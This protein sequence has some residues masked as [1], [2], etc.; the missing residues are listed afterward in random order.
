MNGINF[1]LSA[2][3]IMSPSK[4]LCSLLLNSIRTVQSTV[5]LLHKVVLR[6]KNTAACNTRHSFA[7]SDV[8]KHMGVL[9]LYFLLVKFTPISYLT[10]LTRAI[11]K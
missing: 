5:Q 6:N 9:K 11:E 8:I 3:N 2:K 7:V 10:L 4:T 1:V